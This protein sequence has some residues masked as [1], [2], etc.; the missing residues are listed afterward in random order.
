M[1]EVQVQVRQK[2]LLYFHEF[3]AVIVDIDIGLIRFPSKSSG[4]N[5]FY[6]YATIEECVFI[7]SV[8]NDCV[9]VVKCVLT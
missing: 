5:N 1:N 4:N 7:A 9:H 2:C 3:L 8:A 6:D